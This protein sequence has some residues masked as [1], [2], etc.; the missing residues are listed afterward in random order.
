MAEAAGAKNWIPIYPTC[1]SDYFLI[2]SFPN[3]LF[4]L[5]EPSLIG[6]FDAAVLLGLGHYMDIF[7]DLLGLL[8]F[9]AGIALF[10]LAYWVWNKAFRSSSTGGLIAKLLAAVVL[11]VGGFRVD[12]GMGA[13]DRSGEL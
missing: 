9:L 11:I 10:M 4:L 3:R 12:F 1:I 13:D 7:G 8:M 5:Y 2:W 6:A